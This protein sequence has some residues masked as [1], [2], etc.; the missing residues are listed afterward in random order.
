MKTRVLISTAIVLIV[1]GFFLGETRA[2][3][4][5]GAG[6]ANCVVPAAA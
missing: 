4:Q 5:A 6:G 2:Q 1:G 3:R